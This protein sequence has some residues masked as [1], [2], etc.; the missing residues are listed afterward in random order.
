MIAAKFVLNGVVEECRYLMYERGIMGFLK[1]CI[2]KS[3]YRL[4]SPLYRD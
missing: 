2:L 1:P 3:I 4:V